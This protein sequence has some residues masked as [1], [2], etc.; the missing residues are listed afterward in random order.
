MKLRSFRA[1][2]GALLVDLPRAPLPDPETPA[3]PRFLPTWDAALLT[4]ARRAEVIAEADRP[5][6]FGTK[7]PQSFPTF[8]IDGRVAGTW[9]YEPPAGK[10]T[11]RIE[12]SPFR[13]LDAADRRELEA[14]AERLAAFHA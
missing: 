2:D 5:R 12:L 3:P 9:R 6:I 10:G 4:H 7:T 8:T 14:E 11:G 1:D 13:R